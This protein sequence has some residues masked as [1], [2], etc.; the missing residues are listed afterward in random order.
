[1]KYANIK[2]GEIV[3]SLPKVIETE[4]GTTHNPTIEIAATIGWRCIVAIPEP[5]EGYKVNGWTFDDLDGINCNLV[6]SDME[7]IAEE[8][9]K[10]NGDRWLL[11]NRYIACC[12]QLRT[13]LGQ[14]PNRIKLGF[15]ELVP[16]MA[17]LKAVSSLGYSD[18]RD[19][20]DM[21]NM[22]LIRYDTKW[23]DDCVWHPEVGV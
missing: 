4:I 17:Q 1:M 16:M 12:D 8:N 20:M 2:T 5:P 11:E 15:A 14:T 10:V 13:V 18:L 21:L 22:A 9:L 19:N 6:I 23:W 3:D 7:N